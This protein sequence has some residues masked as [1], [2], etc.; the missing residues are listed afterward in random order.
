MYIK[1]GFKIKTVSKACS[2]CRWIG[3]MP[4]MYWICC[5]VLYEKHQSRRAH[6]PL[7]TPTTSSR[8]TTT[9]GKKYLRDDSIIN[10]CLC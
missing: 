10:T 2:P 3:W 6:V 7:A 5:L 4:S 9:A 1:F 8:R